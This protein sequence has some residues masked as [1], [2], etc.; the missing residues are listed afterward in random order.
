MEVLWLSKRLSQV[1]RKTRLHILTSAR[2]SAP[3]WIAQIVDNCYAKSH[4]C[5]T[6]TSVTVSTDVHTLMSV[7]G[8]I[9]SDRLQ[10]EIFC[11]QGHIH[12][13][14]LLS[15]DRNY[16]CY[17][18]KGYLLFCP[19]PLIRIPRT[20]MLISSACQGYSF[21]KVPLPK[22]HVAC[23]IIHVPVSEAMTS[24][25]CGCN[26]YFSIHS[27]WDIYMLIWH[28]SEGCVSAV[29]SDVCIIVSLKTVSADGLY[30]TLELFC[31]EIQMFV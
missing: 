24:R 13:P 22:H 28:L 9:M 11:R 6:A 1:T 20:H 14:V 2:Y 4:C 18:L 16:T 8:R 3:K 10:K 15:Q 17:R 31:G 30:V 19:S 12:D 26:F 7:P 5:C 27:V 29:H 23:Y 21:E 25:C